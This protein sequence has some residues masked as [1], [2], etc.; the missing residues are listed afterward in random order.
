MFLGVKL[1]LW[2]IIVLFSISILTP[3][4][5][6]WGTL[7]SIFALAINLI[8]AMLIV[9]EPKYNLDLRMH[10]VMYMML[11]VN[12]ALL[13]LNSL[14]LTLNLISST[15]RRQSTRVRRY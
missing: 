10:Y 9:N 15:L 6:K 11:W 12:V 7:G 4:L 3:I 2:M 5:H 1:M 14:I 13:I 8:L